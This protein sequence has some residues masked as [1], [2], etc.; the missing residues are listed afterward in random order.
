MQADLPADISDKLTVWNSSAIDW[1]LA[2]YVP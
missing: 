2:G 1:F